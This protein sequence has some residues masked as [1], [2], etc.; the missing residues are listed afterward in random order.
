MFTAS[1][2]ILRLIQPPPLF[3]NITGGSPPSIEMSSSCSAPKGSNPDSFLNSTSIYSFID[4]N[5][6]YVAMIACDGDSSDGYQLIFAGG[7]LY[8][9]STM[10]CTF[11]PEITTVSA[12]YTYSPSSN[13]IAVK[14][15]Y[16]SIPDIG[17]PAGVSAVTT[18]YNMV[19]FAQGTS[20]NSFGD[21][22]AS[23]LRDGEDLLSAT[24]H[25]LQGVA[26]YSGTVLR[27]CLSQSNSTLARGG[28]PDN[29]SRSISGK[30]HTEF[31]GWEPTLSVFWVLIPG[32]IVAGATIFVV[33]AA[34]ARHAT[35][36]T[37]KDDFDPSNTMQLVS[38][39][40]AGG[41]SGVFAGPRG[42]DTRTAL[43]VPI[44]FGEFEGM[45]RALKTKHRIV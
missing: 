38:A 16:N 40:A 36:P 34:V 35:D 29:L 6:G 24:E 22:M 32:T 8:N 12:D 14:P 30:L 42:N 17:G 28:L 13:N 26:E 3:L 27:A 19:L 23:L 33:L 37:P 20:S 18:I 21:Q 5:D 2:R 7:G 25:Y 11:T 9:F 41:L 4:E 1:R 31:F 10:V 39:S 45:E 44:V 43:D 15:P